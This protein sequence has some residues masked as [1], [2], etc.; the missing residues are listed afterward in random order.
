M[1][2][3]PALKAFRAAHNPPLSQG[4]LG[5]EV[6]VSRMTVFRWEK[7]IRKID[8]DKL[9]VVAEFTGLAPGVLRP[10][11]AALFSPEAAE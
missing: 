7:G 1:A 10:D 11:L 5:E 4:K 3:I 6:G 9:P 8:D 2:A